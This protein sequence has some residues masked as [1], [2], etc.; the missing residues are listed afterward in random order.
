MLADE[1][2]EFAISEAIEA[3]KPD[4]YP[5]DYMVMDYMII[6]ENQRLEPDGDVTETV[7]LIFKRGRIRHAVALGLLEAAKNRMKSIFQVE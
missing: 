5:N 6:V 4:G 7:N 3:Y 1:K 2:L